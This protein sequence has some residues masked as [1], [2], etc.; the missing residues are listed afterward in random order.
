[1]KKSEKALLKT[2]REKLDLQESGYRSVHAT[3]N[4]AAVRREATARHL[5][6]PAETD[7]P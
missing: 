7:P 2:I 3:P 5:L 1:M 4:S 6:T